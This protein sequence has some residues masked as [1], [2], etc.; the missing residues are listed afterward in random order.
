MIKNITESDMTFQ[1][2]TDNTFE[3]ETSAFVSVL[4]SRLCPKAKT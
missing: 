2:E 4:R 1:V 3:I